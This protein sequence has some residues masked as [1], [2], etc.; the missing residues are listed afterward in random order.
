MPPGRRS[1]FGFVSSS[2]GAKGESLKSRLGFLRFFAVVKLFRGDLPP[3]KLFQV[4]T[5]SPQGQ[6]GLLL[7]VYFV[8]LLRAQNP[9]VCLQP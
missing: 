9:G 3:F 5:E 2:Q 4:D 7:L 1:L 8:C 6:L